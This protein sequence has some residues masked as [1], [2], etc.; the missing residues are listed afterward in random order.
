[1]DEIISRD[2]N[3]CFKKTQKSH[4]RLQMFASSFCERGSLILVDNL[5]CKY[6]DHICEQ[7]C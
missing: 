1:M 4:I 3:F 7:I 5:T 6:G 2:R